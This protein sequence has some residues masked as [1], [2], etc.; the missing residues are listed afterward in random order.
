LADKLNVKEA[1][2]KRQGGPAMN[3]IRTGM[4][5]GGL[6]TG[7]DT[8]TMV[9]DLV[10]A[11]RMRADRLTQRRTQL[12]WRQEDIR[13]LNT[14]LTTLRNR[15][16]DMT[17][18]GTYRR[19]TAASSN[20]RA[21]TASP[22]GDASA[23]G[24]EFAAISRL[25]AAARATS[26]GSIVLAPH[27]SINT[28]APLQQLISEGRIDGAGLPS[29]FTVTL[30]NHTQAGTR[31]S[32]TFTVN[33][34]TDSLN[35][36]L[37]RINNSQTLGMQAFYD[38]FSGRVSIASRF[39]GNNN[40]A[41][42]DIGFEGAGAAFFTTTL[43][44]AVTDGQ[45]AQFTLNGLATERPTNNFTINGVTFTLRNTLAA[46]ET[47]TVT[48]TPDRDAVVRSIEEFVKVYNDTLEQFNRELA[49]KLHRD[50]LPLT[51]AQKE[52]MRDEDITRWQERARSG[53]LRGD[54][55][56]ERIVGR[57]RRDFTDP[58]SGT[59]LGQVTALGLRTGHHAEQGRLHLN[60]ETLRAALERDSGAVQDLFSR[61]A[62][63]LRT[64]LE[65]G[66]RELSA[67]AGTA[68]SFARVD[69]SV[70]GNQMRR[71]DERIDRENDRIA[72]VEDRL[73]RQFT[74]LEQAMERMNNQS[75]WLAQQFA[76]RQQ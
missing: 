69:S 29:T 46:G 73:W 26:T 68:V 41:G 43:R 60:T 36:V 72:R 23:M 65:A 57:M 37:G 39:T 47:A 7:L 21:V 12:E 59:V 56:L 55:M 31:V 15:T 76:P 20:E 75:A 32:E 63:R 8:E 6:A 10:R 74:A 18:Q 45:N 19:I 22:T 17:L 53:L 27:T 25:A 11:E 35:T 54:D 3:N 62:G 58:V 70:I 48:V 38:E 49:E 67:Q 9:R 13:A 4:R 33:T 42:A 61:V 2:N 51:G 50:F 44:L 1:K 30:F 14:Q 52:E 64:S 28:N 40:Q 71:L 66:V 5:F 24:F 34:A 16:F